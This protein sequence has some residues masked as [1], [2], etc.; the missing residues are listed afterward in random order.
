MSKLKIL[1]LLPLIYMTLFNPSLAMT[2]D[3]DYIYNLIETS[4]KKQISTPDQGQLEIEVSPIDPRITLQPCLSALSANIPENH[5]GRNVNV[6]VVCPDETPWQLFVPVRIQTIVPILVAR[7][8]MAKG[9]LLDNT[10]IEVIFKDSNQIRGTV[11]TDPSIVIGARTKRNLSQGSAITSR[12]TC[13]VCKGQPVNIVAKS[14]SFE[15]K[16]F[17]IALKDGSLG[18]LI[19]VKNKKSG[20]VVQGQVNAINQVVINL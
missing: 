1:V 10:N 16:S 13:F 3:R 8:R 18:E 17:G 20:R 12:N 15:I 7:V 5:N 4:V 11:L 2:L 9:T 19:P 14:A 6:K